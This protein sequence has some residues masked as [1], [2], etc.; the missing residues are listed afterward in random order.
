MERA[1]ETAYEVGPPQLAEA[2]RLGELHVA[3]WRDAY[4]GLLPQHV[5]DALDPAARA[6][7]WR[8]I[9]ARVDPDGRD[10]AVRWLVARWSG[11]PVGMIGVGAPRDDD[12]PAPRELWVLNVAR[13]HRGRG[14]AQALMASGLPPGPAYLWVLAGN[15]RAIDFY[16]KHGFRLDGTEKYDA[17]QEGVDLRM[18]R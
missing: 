8:A 13:E 10:G 3:V 11:S 17:A 7:R 15:A 5:L 16:A 6:E 1:A 14:A 9:A 12:P 2:E 4:A 18:V